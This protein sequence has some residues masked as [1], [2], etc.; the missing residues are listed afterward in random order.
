MQT[1]LAWLLWVFLLVPTL[2]AEDFHIAFWNVENLFDTVDDPAVEL[3]EE[4][5]PTAEKKWTEERLQQKLTNLARIISAMHEKRGPDILGL[6]EV[7]NR[8]VVEM[9]VEKL[10][11][12]QRRYKVVHQNSPSL[13]GIDCA[14]IYDAD[15][16]DLQEA[17]FHS[18]KTMHPTRD[19]LEAELKTKNAEK[20]SV[21]VNHWPSRRNPESERI[22]AAG[23]LRK[24]LDEIF[25]QDG[26]ADVII[27]GD[28]NDYPTDVSL[29]QH[30]Q[31]VE[32]PADARDGKLLNTMWP[33]HRKGGTGSYVFNDKWEIIDHIFISPGLLDERNFRWQA[34][35]TDRAI[36]VE[37][38]LYQPRPP[39]IARPSRSYSGPIFHRTGYSDHLPVQ[40]ILTR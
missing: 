18:V 14:L 35:S 33:M 38:Q 3:D 39:A 27:V 24:R 29:T 5:T 25:A 8:E 34:G 12:L 40:A 28:F 1:R 11:P 13:R 20:L 36:L 19:I 2:Q 32:N 26:H 31:S 6:A 17:K 23:V 37:N 4:Y 7:E 22:A 15:K 21:F 9:L 10:K 30:L 16:F